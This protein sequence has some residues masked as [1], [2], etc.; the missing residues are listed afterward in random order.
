MILFF[1]MFLLGCKKDDPNPELKDKIYLDLVNQEAIELKKIEDSVAKIQEILKSLE[2][3]K[4]QTG[5]IKR[6]TIKLHDFENIKIK[7]QQQL[8]MWRILKFERLKYVRKS[9]LALDEDSW[10]KTSEHEFEK[11][12]AEKKLIRSKPYW[13]I[14]DRFKESGYKFDPTLLGEGI[15]TEEKK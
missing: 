2:K 3:S 14:K 13:D 5:D 12:Y 11:Y 7:Q 9:R 8:K 4:P 10:N 1:L 6:N 15:K